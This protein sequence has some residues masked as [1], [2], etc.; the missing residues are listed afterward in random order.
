MEKRRFFAV[1]GSQTS[2]S[3][4]SCRVKLGVWSGCPPGTHHIS[5]CTKASSNR[6]K[7]TKAMFYLLILSPHPL[8]Q[9]RAVEWIWE[10]VKSLPRNNLVE[11]A[12][13]AEWPVWHI[14]RKWR[15]YI[16]LHGIL[17]RFEVLSNTR[18]TKHRAR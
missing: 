11:Q 17:G 14:W 5:M 15:H 2:T 16:I 7:G 4:S 13:V 3:T 6:N 18:T 10:L 12:D 1:F 9:G 8:G